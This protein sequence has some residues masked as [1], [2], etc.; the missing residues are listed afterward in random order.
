MAN[1][2]TNR[3]VQAYETPGPLLT[4]QRPLNGHTRTEPTDADEQELIEAEKSLATIET[5]RQLT[6][7]KLN[8]ALAEQQRLTDQARE[9]QARR[10][11]AL[12]NKRQE[13]RD[14]ATRYRQWALEADEKE[15]ADN[16]VAWAQEEEQL[17]KGIII[18][19]EPDE[20]PEVAPK[21]KLAIW[22]RPRVH[23]ALAALQ[24]V[25]LAVVLAY[26]YGLFQEFRDS[27]VQEN[28]RA[29]EHAKRT[30]DNI[31][32]LM[33]PFDDTAFQKYAFESF[34]EFMDLPKALLKMLILAP[35]LLYYLYRRFL[36]D[37]FEGLTPFQRCLLVIL[38]IGL[39]LLHSGLSHL[40]KAD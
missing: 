38:F 24:F 32:E 33:K 21:P 6:Q 30:G 39:L 35:F 5:E 8:E 26:T 36:R 3:T 15:K 14:N 10:V 7:A 13:H 29:I 16:Y 23:S 18:E 4:R 12:K 22:Q 2:K 25:L 27:M 17:A 40:V 34:V 31:V 37:F 9:A 19:G 28:T 20:V 11:Q 1:T